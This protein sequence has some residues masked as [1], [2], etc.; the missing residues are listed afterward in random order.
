MR[1][2]ET[3]VE[4]FVNLSE[5]TEIELLIMRR[6]REFTI[7]EHRSL[8]H[9]SGFDFVGLRD[10]QAG[11]RMSQ[12]DWPQSTLTNFSPLVVR[13]YEQRST[14]TVICVADG[15]LSTRCGIDGVPIAAAIARAIGTI[16]MSAVFFQDM[17]GLITFDAKFENLGAVRP[18]IGKNQVIHCLDAYQFHQGV[19]P[20]KRADTL[21]MSLAGFMRK[22]SMVPVIS[23]FLFDDAGQVLNELALLNSAHDVFIVLIDSAFA[24][25]LPPISAG[26]IEAFDVET[27]RSRVMSRGALNAL[28][29]KTRSWQDEVSRMAKTAGLD[30]LRIGV[31]EQQ[32]AIALSEF[33]AERRLRKAA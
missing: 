16:G 33:I 18:R 26:W 20:L 23:D 28:S 22:T 7:G 6:M 25:E 4:P 8:F 5:L 21:S 31:D 24:F 2:R 11:D 27:G 14:A 9:G 15:S 30:V 12:I 19:Q 29:A 3:D 13:D 10:W 17:F 1:T 32:T